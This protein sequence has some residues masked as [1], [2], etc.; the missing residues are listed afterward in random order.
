[1]MIILNSKLKL[2]IKEIFRA[3]TKNDILQPYISDDAFRFS[4]AGVV[5][6]GYNSYVFD[7]R[8]PQN[9]IASQPNKTGF[10]FDGI[11]PCDVNGFALVLT[12]NLVFLFS[13]RQK[14]FDLI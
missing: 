4:N 1:M 6:N 8:Y 7:V 10:K 13:D 5:L 11:V 3:L 12:N 2:K 14:D 9:F